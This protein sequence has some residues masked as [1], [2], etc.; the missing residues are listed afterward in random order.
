MAG[1][2][3]AV[4]YVSIVPKMG[5]GFTKTVESALS[6]SG[7]SGAK[8]FSAS[9]TGGIG[10]AG[11]A[12]GNLITG[13]IST[14]MGAVSSSLDSA[15]SR[16]DTLNQFPQVMS[17]LGFSTEEADA[18]L[19]KLSDGIQGLPTA[20]DEIVGNAQTL[21]LTLGDLGRGTDVALALN[22]GLL[23]YG[24]SAEYVNNAVFQL[25]QMISAGSYDMQSWRSV[26]E[27]APGY[28]DQVAVACLGAGS[29]ANDL[30]KALNEGTVTTDQFLSAIVALDQEGGEGI[31]AFSEQ[32]KSATGGIATSFANVGTAVT[33]NLANFID[34]VNG[35]D[36]RIAAFA[37]SLKQVVNDIG[38]AL[39][40]VG[41]ALG[42]AFASFT[43]GFDA[44]YSSLSSALGGWGEALFGSDAVVETFEETSQSADELL[45][46]YQA[47]FD[48]VWNGDW[49]NGEEA[50]RQAFVDAG[51]SAEQYDAVQ[52]LVNEHG[53][54]Y[55]L[56]ME[57]LESVLGDVATSTGKAETAT[58]KV[59]R[60]V[61]E[62]TK[63]ALTPY[64]DGLKGMVF[65]IDETSDAFDEFGAKVGTVTT[66][67]DGLVDDLSQ[68]WGKLA[69]SLG[70]GAGLGESLSVAVDFAFDFP[71][72]AQSSIDDACSKLDSLAGKAKDAAA[73]V[74]PSAA[75]AWESFTG[76]LTT[77][78]G[79]AFD[80]ALSFFSQV[81]GPLEGVVGALGDLASDELGDAS[82]VFD[83]IAESAP[84]IA[85]TF[86]GSLA[87]VFSNV[88]G[89]LT[90]M[91]PAVGA[92]TGF[93]TD[94][95]VALVGEFADNCGGLA[96][97]LEDASG[98]LRSV[99]EEYGP[100]FAEFFEGL[101]VGAVTG[102]LSDLAS[103]L[104]DGVGGVIQTMADETLPDFQE[105]W[106]TVAEYFSSDEYE[107]AN[108]LESLGN[109]A[110]AAFGTICIAAETAMEVVGSLALALSRFFTG[111]WAG[112]AEAIGE[113][114]SSVVD[115]AC[116]EVDYLF[117]TDLTGWIQW[118]N[119]ELAG[120]ERGLVALDAD[121]SGFSESLG[122]V[123][124]Y[125]QFSSLATDL[126]ASAEAM[127]ALNAAMEGG[128]WSSLSL[129]AS[130]VLAFNAALE[131][132][133]E[134]GAA[135]QADLL[136]QAF[137]ITEQAVQD[138]TT[139]VETLGATA[140]D[141]QQ[142]ADSM[143]KVSDAT[144]GMGDAASE[145]SDLGGKLSDAATGAQDATSALNSVRD[146]AAGT[147]LDVT[148]D[149]AKQ[150]IDNLNE[151]GSVSDVA[152][153][154]VQDGATV[155][156][157][158]MA[159][160][161]SG[162]ESVNSQFDGMASR[163][164][165]VNGKLQTLVSYNGATITLNIVESTTT[166]G[167]SSSSTPTAI[168]AHASGGVTNGVH[169]IGEAGPEAIVPL[170]AGAMDPFARQVSDFIE[171]DLGGGGS[172]YNVYVNDARINDD[173]AI[174]SNVAGLLWDLDRLGAI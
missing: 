170:Y 51:Y 31:V 50:R 101:D 92:L 69:E 140:T 168:S 1:T 108:W 35:E 28:L 8:S 144:G 29:G 139:A 84:T 68:F 48:Q 151:T 39:L 90:A 96:K 44:A 130:D 125:A 102:P 147:Q 36:G 47:L 167:S 6:A 18:A 166:T 161:D 4:G 156:S 55:V 162:A 79:T 119:G 53:A 104:R 70:S 74:A 62:A 105:A 12:A 160:L 107:G 118:L 158:H 87:T 98:A 148:A 9:F 152:L 145:V 129:G 49:G 116:E 38:A 24:A 60:T 78:A 85:Q 94:S 40:P 172:V 52:Q 123:E 114:L 15:I 91:E 2:E 77:L 45:G 99:A 10:A 81:E 146:A 112:A 106:E 122:N 136:A 159:D 115:G 58:R 72:D 103:T 83:A 25:N 17:N 75:R 150:L 63:G 65:G 134:S 46:Q 7:A 169:I 121:F 153:V 131:Q 89:A 86:T 43:D 61:K 67:T 34:A 80:S 23:T 113:G 143:S 66:H 88:A 32:A 11:V 27:S 82:K 26:M 93:V 59:E 33:R 137:G 95:F 5:S 135:E 71:A 64:I 127:G 124:A 174:R 13:A 120:T 173:E 132:M 111:D 76:C 19:S 14:A 133:R 141:T 100:K 57:D 154:K 41:D 97:P 30:R 163:L 126:G 157:E 21:S 37:D 165:G 128:S 16:V 109:V 117:G 42:G 164:D 20:L 22:D 155:A 138:A 149:Q 54:D 171:K 56:T 110:E 73:S 142:L 3:V